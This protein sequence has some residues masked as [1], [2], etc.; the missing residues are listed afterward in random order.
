MKGI[1][2]NEKSIKLG[3]DIIICEKEKYEY[4][5]NS[6]KKDN[7]LIVGAGPAGLFCAYELCK[8]GYQI[9]LIDRG[10]KVEDRIKSVEEFW[11]NGSLNIN[12]NISQLQDSFLSHKLP[13]T[14]P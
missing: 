6:S 3:N 9:T 14:I 11:N 12:S 8:N 1:L 5:V 13:L 10:E 4:K 7:I 2:K